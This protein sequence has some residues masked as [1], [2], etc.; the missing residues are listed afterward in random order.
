MQPSIIRILFYSLFIPFLVLEFCKAA[1]RITS[2]ESI[3][4]G[5]TL[6]S[7]GKI[8]ELGFFS[9][10]GSKSTSRYLGIWYK[11]F[12]KIVVWIAN[13]EIPVTGSN[14]VLTISTD[15]NLVI[16]NCMTNR[17][18]WSSNS[19]ATVQSSRAQILDSGNLVLR[20]NSNTSFGSHIWQSFDFPSDTL[21]PGMK[22]GWNL[23]SD[24][25]RYLTSWKDT[26]DP[27]PGDFT[28]R[29]D[30]LGLPQF[31]LRQGSEKKFRTGPWIGLRYSGTYSL[32]SPVLKFSFVSN[33]DELY[34]MF[35]FSSDSVLTRVTLKQ[36]GVIQ[37]SVLSEGNPDWTIMYTSPNNLCD[38]YGWCGANGICR[39]NNN[40]ICGCL[41]GFIPK[42][43]RQWDVLDWSSGCA[44][45]MPLD[46][47]KGEGFE[48]LK[49]VK[50]P[51][52]LE[53][54]LNEGMDLNQCEAECLKN[55]SCTA[56]A[57][58]DIRGGGTGCL[59]WFGDLIDI[60][61]FSEEGSELDIYIRMPASE[62]EG[63]K[64][65]T[66][67]GIHINCFRNACSQLFD[68]AYE[69]D[70]EKEDRRSSWE[71]RNITSDVK[72]I[73]CSNSLCTPMTCIDNKFAFYVLH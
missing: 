58:S 9:P 19:S 43:Q 56:F 49:N 17:V 15:G 20:E 6:I 21:L 46:C 41:E 55:C 53:F 13:R 47:Q 35:E 3:R 5:E 66:I 26:S 1:D 48:K 65:D 29:I 4:D 70:E 69:A 27:S 7:K 67:D 64:T 2:G 25:N 68:L 10:G 45:K 60:R 12:P 31:V 24:Q 22:L 8:F 44:R 37:H 11:K 34:Q 57:N 39:I 52:L 71:G 14:G 50:L 33:S 42:S 54:R 59:N 51:D 38:N 40:P 62:L 72:V 73:C 32:R 16:L 61:E 30:N 23:T 63:E 36:P 18:V 28:C